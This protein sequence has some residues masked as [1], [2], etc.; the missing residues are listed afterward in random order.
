[1]IIRDDA[2]PKGTQR[3]PVPG[4]GST[5]P[6]T[7]SPGTTDP[8]TT[9]PGTT[10]PQH[11][12]H[13][14][15]STGI[16]APSDPQQKN[17]TDT[18]VDSSCSSPENDS[19]RGGDSSAKSISSNEARGQGHSPVASTSRARPLC[20]VPVQA[21]SSSTTPRRRT[22]ADPGSESGTGREVVPRVVECLKGAGPGGGA[23]SK[24]TQGS[25][26]WFR[27]GESPLSL[28]QYFLLL[29][30]F[31]ACVSLLLGFVM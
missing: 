14:G 22:G 21:V 16:N 11:T 18:P 24:S 5:D 27:P 1:M 13:H 4:T 31:V 25:K 23:T 8:G 3:L 29:F 28:S 9:D 19:W 6:G 12:R 10:S 15:G 17:H 26:H 2:R 20:V 7:T 30:L